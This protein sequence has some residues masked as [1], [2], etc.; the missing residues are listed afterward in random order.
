[1]SI[2]TEAPNTNSLLHNKVPHI[3]I[4]KIKGILS[5]DLNRKKHILK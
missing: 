2:Y 3:D 4:Y 5:A 1:M